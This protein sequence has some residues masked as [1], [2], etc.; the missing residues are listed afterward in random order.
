MANIQKQF[1]QFHDIIRLDD[2]NDTLR[3]KRDRVLKRLKDGLA[4]IFEE[5][6][7][8]VPTFSHFNQGSYAMGTGVIPLDGDF[9]IDIGIRFKISKEDYAPVEVK[10]WVHEAL[11]N[12]TNRVE[13]RKPCVTV[14]YS[15]NDE[16]IYHVDLAIYSDSANND[17]GN[18]YLA[19]GKRNSAAEHRYWEES[20]PIGLISLIRDRYDVAE[21]RSQFRRVIRY[22]KRWK[23]E[24]F[25]TS[26]NA[27]P[28]GI[29]IT[30]AAFYW[31]NSVYVISDPFSGKRTYDDLEAML[32]LVENIISHFQYKFIENEWVYRLVVELP[33]APGKDLFEKMTNNQ[34][35]N[36]K[37]RLD[38]LR[39]ALQEAKGEAAPEEA[40]KIL[41]KHL[42]GEFPI[43]PKQETAKVTAPAVVSSNS[44]A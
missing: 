40:C 39:D 34:S 22:M 36:L 20:D 17:D 32:R 28:L 16:P 42:G 23:D 1:E 24:K 14:Y 19:K 33:V 13:I 10:E 9:D 3:E 30:V 11:E 38:D 43:P 15:K 27:A 21:D 18:T 26:G 41:A 44:Q 5:K 29:G 31:F 25:S 8:P 4:K 6:E 35:N 7:E 37:L 2:E 12:H